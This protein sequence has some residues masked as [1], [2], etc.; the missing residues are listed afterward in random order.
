M[1][2][3][4]EN[5]YL[6]GLIHFVETGESPIPSREGEVS[7]F[8]DSWGEVYPSIMSDS[9]MGNVKDFDYSLEKLLASSKDPK[10]SQH[11]TSC[12]AY[13]TILGRLF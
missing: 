11:W 1:V 10:P 8:M 5:R 6:K 12:E 3:F 2:V 9:K 7:V 4:V 13:Q